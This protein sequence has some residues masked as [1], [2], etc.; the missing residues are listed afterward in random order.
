MP[1]CNSGILASDLAGNLYINP[2]YLQT[3]ERVNYLIRHY[4]SAGILYSHLHNFYTSLK[5]PYSRHHHQSLNWQN[6]NFKQVIGVSN[7]LFINKI[8]SAAKLEMKCHDSETEIRAYLQA[9]N[10]RIS[11]FLESI[12]PPSKPKSIFDRTSRRKEYKKSDLF[13]K[14]YQRLTANELNIQYGSVKTYKL[15][16]HL[17]EEIYNN[18]LNN[19]VD[20]WNAIS[21]YIWLM[22]HSTGELQELMLQPLQ[23][24]VNYLV[25]FWSISYWAFSHSF[26]SSL[27]KRTQKLTDLIRREEKQEKHKNEILELNSA[28]HFVEVT[29]TFTSVMMQLYQWHK[30]LDDTYLENLFACPSNLGQTN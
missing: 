23:N 8:I 26:I 11:C 15:K 18:A 21:T 22:A 1:D 19:I 10:P 4:L 25:K 17:K 6:I 27:Q 2:S 7:D 12:S 29:F 9:V 20:Q 3:R 13:R 30:T 28:L 24:E 14:I 5:T 16:G